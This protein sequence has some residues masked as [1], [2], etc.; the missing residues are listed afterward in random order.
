M[1]MDD[2]VKTSNLDKVSLFVES[3]TAKL[4]QACIA[5]KTLSQII[6]K[7]AYSLIEEKKK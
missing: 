2:F 1:F 4:D 7:N 5:H 3:F 6:I